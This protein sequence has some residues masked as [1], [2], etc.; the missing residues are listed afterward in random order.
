[1]EQ[2]AIALTGAAAIWLVNDRRAVWRRWASVIGLAGQPF[3]FHAAIAAEQWGVLAL[4][5]IYTAA[6]VRGWWNEWRR[7]GQAAGSCCQCQGPACPDC[8]RL[9]S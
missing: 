3:W 4:T 5:C 7:P 6:W 9:G 1:M 8:G 2:L